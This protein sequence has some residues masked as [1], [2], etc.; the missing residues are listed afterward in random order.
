[1]SSPSIFTTLLISILVTL[2]YPLFSSLNFFHDQEDFSTQARKAVKL[3]FFIS[4]FPIFIFLSLGTEA[5]INSW[6]WI[7]T[8]TFSFSISFKFDFYSVIFIPVALFV[9]WS[10]LD[11]ASWYIHSDPNI[12]RFFKFLLIFLMAILVLTSANNLFQLF[13]GWEGVGIISF[14]LI[15][16]WHG[17]INANAAALQ[18]VVYNRVGDIGLL[19]A[20]ASFATISDSWELSQLSNIAVNNDLTWPIVGL[21]VAATGK[22]AQFG[23]HAWLPSAI[24]GP[25]PVSALLHSSTIVVAGIFLIIRTNTLIGSSSTILSLCLCLGAITTVFAALCALTQNDIKKVIAFSTSSQLGLIIVAIGLNKPNLAF[26][27]ICTHAFFKAILFI[28][29]GSVIHALN[30]EQDIRKIGSIHNLSPVTSS[31]ITLGSLALAGTPF[32]AGFF[33]KDAIV[34]AA[35]SSYLNAWSLLVTLLAISFTAVYSLRLAFLSTIGL[36][37]FN[38]ISPISE[39]T[40]ELSRPLKR[41]GWGSI[42]A[43]LTIASILPPSEASELTFPLTLKLIAL[44]VSF[45]G[46]L[47]ALDLS[48]LTLSQAKV[49]PISIPYFF[50]SL[51]GFFPTLTHRLSTIITLFLGQIVASQTLDHT[52]YEKLIPKTLQASNMLV[53]KQVTKTKV[54]IKTFLVSFLITLVF[55]LILFIMLE[56]NPVLPLG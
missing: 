14:L 11:F 24:E 23:L 8:Q 7:N 37:R 45:A 56:A 53:V 46:I 12:Q 26:F 55:S 3:A 10:I 52:W 25:T 33:S 49:N 32:L 50:S 2:S 48:S 42:F 15:S 31:C 28:C 21:I 36:P 4:L 39:P 17:R 29:S 20:I 19:F 13:I 51:L 22:S 43:G 5:V 18:A 40:I 9:T 6:T 44:I 34:E 47:I 35:T 16:W 1:M 41:L 54:S 38:S 27:H 30:G